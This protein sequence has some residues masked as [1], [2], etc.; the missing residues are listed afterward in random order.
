MKKLTQDEF[1]ATLAAPMIEV[2]LDAPPPFEF[3]NYF[4]EIPKADF[5]G[6]D[7][8]DESVTYAWN[9]PDGTFQHVLVDSNRENAFMVLVLDL[10]KNR[11]YGHRVLTVSDEYEVS[12]Y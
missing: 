12:E 10:K 6:L 1:L 5:D 11:V 4:D 7:C 3:W 8:G 2:P 9:H